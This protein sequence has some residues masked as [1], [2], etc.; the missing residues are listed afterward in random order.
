MCEGAWGSRVVRPGGQTTGPPKQS[1]TLVP[2]QQGDPTHSLS[3][4][5]RW[6]NNVKKDDTPI[7]ARGESR[8]E[9]TGIVVHV[10]E[11]SFLPREGLCDVRIA[12]G[13]DGGRP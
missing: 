11:D 13:R 6:I 1:T 5:P 9:T 12:R 7:S 3:S 8:F 4:R 2:A 10:P